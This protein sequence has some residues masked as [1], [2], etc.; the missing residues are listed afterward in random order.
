MAE[1]RD[2]LG[3]ACE[4]PGGIGISGELV[5]QELQ[6]HATG[7][8]SILSLID[9]A[10][11]PDAELADDPVMRNRLTNHRVE[12]SPLFAFCPSD[13]ITCERGFPPLA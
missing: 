12:N 11:T 7:K 2:G 13:V 10:H 9:D 8:L 5:G 4:P 3:F 6:R 1:V